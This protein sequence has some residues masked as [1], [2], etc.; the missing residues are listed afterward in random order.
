MERPFIAVKR[1]VYKSWTRI[2]ENEQFSF[3]H[4]DRMITWLI[5]FSVGGI[6]AIVTSLSAF[7][8][9]FEG[10]IRVC[11]V[12]FLV[13]VVFFG[14]IGRLVYFF[15]QKDMRNRQ[16]FF[17]TAFSDNEMMRIEQV[18]ISDI[19]DPK[20]LAR[21]LQ[22]DFGVNLY[23]EIVNFEVMPPEEQIRVI[24][25]LQNHY[26]EYSKWAKEDFENGIEFIKDTY[27]KGYGLSTESVDKMFSPNAKMK[28]AR[29]RVLLKW[30]YFLFSMC[31]FSFLG[32]IIIVFIGVIC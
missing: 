13:L 5:G 28:G 3:E 23:S 16:I 17:H 6:F 1:M 14:I 12:S 9:L 21:F 31:L 18:D 25:R 11:L 29:W 8:S 27:Q 26:N 4:L 24:K 20:K 19:D 15:Y 32:L 22:V 10:W 2:Q 7:N 30:S